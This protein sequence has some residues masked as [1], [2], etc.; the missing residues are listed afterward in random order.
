MVRGDARTS[1]HFQD[2]VEM[3]RPPQ[4]LRVIRRARA[5]SLGPVLALVSSFCR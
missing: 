3:S 2:L 4:F 5:L 1:R